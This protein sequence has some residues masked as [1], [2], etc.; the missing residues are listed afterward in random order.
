MD[1]RVTMK[2][3]SEKLELSINAVSLAL[4]NKPGVSEDTRRNILKVADELGYFEKKT[5]YINTFACR[6]IS[7]L[8]EQRFFH[9]PYFYSKVI[10]GIEE[11]AKKN[12]YDVIVSFIDTKSYSAP[13]SLENKKVCG[14][15]ALGVI[16][17]DYILSL[18]KYGL[19]IVLVDNTCFC[20]SMD[21]VLTDNKIGMYK[22]TKYLIDKGKTKIGFFGDLN[23]SLSIKERYFGFEQA[24]KKYLLQDELNFEKYKNRFSVLSNIEKYVIKN[25]IK[26]VIDIVKEIK[27]MPEAFV[28]SNDSVAI[29]LMNALNIL[30]YKVPDDISILGF[31]D[32]VLSGLVKPEL[33]T[34]RVN[35]ELMGRK[36]V[37]RLLWRINNKK[38]PIE[39]MVI[40]VELIERNSVK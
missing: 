13:N 32:N 6:N 35:K 18:K 34:V 26:V 7:L 19:P 4:N 38:E 25:D 37:Q 5:K 1:K 31:D 33:T 17:D 21:S 24:I 22:A 3:I 10:K 39:H 8:M 14:V 12:K 16:S 29:M 15:I 9:D 28:C 20:E 36:A 30:G 40:G 11:E 2:D 27:E 23:Y